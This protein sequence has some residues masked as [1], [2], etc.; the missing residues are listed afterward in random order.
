M[1]V[2]PMDDHRLHHLSATQKG[3]ILR[4]FAELLS[5]EADIAFA[6]LYG[7]LTERE[8]I[9]D[10]DVGI[11]LLPIVDATNDTWTREAKLADVFEA[12]VRELAGVTI[13][14][15]VRVMNNAPVPA[16]FRVLT[17]E[18]IQLADRDAFATVMEWVVP[19]YLDLKPLRDQAIRDLLSA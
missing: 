8:D 15:D 14:V 6:F 18:R 3:E 13:P 16:Q 9:H 1:L 11:Y 19:R 10:I 4:A 12:R 7:S 5:D 17:G 2:L